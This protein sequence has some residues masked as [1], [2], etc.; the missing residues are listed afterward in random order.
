M[1]VLADTCLGMRGI[2]DKEVIALKQ[3]SHIAWYHTM[4]QRGAVN[5][6]RKFLG[7]EENARLMRDSWERSSP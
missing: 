5:V 4:S 3:F 7:V 1:S 2:E 6:M